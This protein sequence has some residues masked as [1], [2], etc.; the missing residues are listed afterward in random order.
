MI[1]GAKIDFVRGIP[2][3]ATGIGAT[4]GAFRIGIGGAGTACCRVGAGGPDG[5]G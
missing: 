4:R 3:T 5:I 1:G 2:A